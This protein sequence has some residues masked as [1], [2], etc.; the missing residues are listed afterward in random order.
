VRLPNAEQAIVD[1]TK[2]RDYVLSDMHPRG[3]H[4]AR[5]F[6]SALGLT[7]A[8]GDELQ[9]LLLQAA[10]TGDAVEGTSDEFGTRY[11]IDF[12]IVRSGKRARVRS[13]WIV[14]IDNGRPRM[15]TCYVL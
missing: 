12:E 6:L 4:K 2:L 13:S 9:N 8:A 15:I 1:I 7:A 3:R 10:R 14:P 5:V 11:T